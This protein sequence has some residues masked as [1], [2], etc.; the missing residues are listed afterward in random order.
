M[1][2]RLNVGPG[3]DRRSITV[4][5]GY[6]GELRSLVAQNLRAALE[7]AQQRWGKWTTIESISTPDTIYSDLTGRT[8]GLHTPGELGGTYQDTAAKLRAR[9]YNPAPG[10]TDGLR[11]F[12]RPHKVHGEKPKGED[13]IPTAR[14]RGQKWR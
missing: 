9:G 7:D 6:R 2:G 8:R 3:G 12:E 5:F 13:L 1:S 11:F 10:E 14:G 4:S